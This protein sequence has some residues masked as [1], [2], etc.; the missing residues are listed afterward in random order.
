MDLYV[1]KQVTTEYG[2][3]VIVQQL[4][5]QWW[6]VETNHIEDEFTA[7]QLGGAS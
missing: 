6:V 7:E 1:G 2:S 5:E 4:G 3:G